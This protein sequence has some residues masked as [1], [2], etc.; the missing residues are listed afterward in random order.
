MKVA[1]LAEFDPDDEYLE[2]ELGVKAIDGALA[3]AKD[4]L[5]RLGGIQ[6][7]SWKV[8]RVEEVK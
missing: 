7:G 5:Y 4:R 8:L 2:K 6:L 3:D 1:I